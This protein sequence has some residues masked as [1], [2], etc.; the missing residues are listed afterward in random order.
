V[1]EVP[2]SS[3]S[4]LSGCAVPGLQQEHASEGLS[5]HVCGDLCLSVRRASS[6]MDI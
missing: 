2:L 3:Y 1:D 5:Q 6:I 4:Q